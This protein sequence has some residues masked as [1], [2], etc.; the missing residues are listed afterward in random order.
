MTKFLV[1]YRAPRAARQ[2]MMA[3]S[4]PEQAKAGMDAWMGWATRTG[5]ALV[6]L[7]APLGAGTALGGAGAADDFG[8]YSVVQAKDLDA[9]KALFVDHPH[10]RMPGGSIVLFE[11][12][13]M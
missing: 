12:V 5:S 4:T 13:K 10:H 6:D 1:I 9:A 7:G 3:E 2:A 8:G 11:C